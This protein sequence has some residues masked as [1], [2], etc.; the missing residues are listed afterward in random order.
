[1]NKILFFSFTFL[2]FTNFVFSQKAIIKGV[3]KDDEVGETLINATIMV[4]ELQGVGVVT[5]FDGNYNIELDE[6]EYTFVISYVGFQ[7]IEKKVN[8]KSNKITYLNASLKSIVINEVVVVADIAKTRETPVAFTNILPAKIEE[9]LAAQDMPMVL[10]STPGVYATQQGGGDG[11]ARITIRGFSQENIAV[12]LDGIPMNDM[13]SGRVY[14]SNWFG[15]D[16]VTRSMQVQRGLGSSKLAVPSVGGTVN[17]LTKGI[18]NK[19]GGSF[20]QDVGSFGYKRTTIGFNTGELKH[21][22]GLTFAASYKTKD[23]YIDNT[24]SEAL[25]YYFKIDKRFNLH[26]LSFSVMNAPQT[27]ASRPY[28][29]AISSYDHDYARELGIPL[30][31]VSNS[32]DTTEIK[33]R[34]RDY[35]DHWG[36]LERFDIDE[37]GDTIHA[38]KEIFREKENKYQ[39]PVFTLKDFWTLDDNLYLSTILYASVGTGGMTSKAASSKNGVTGS[40]SSNFGFDEDGQLDFQSVY[41]IN[42]FGTRQHNINLMPKEY[43]WASGVLAKDYNS[44]N[45]F[46]L[47]STLNYNYSDNL[48]FSG[49]VDLRTYEGMHYRQIEDLLG[50]D[51]FVDINDHTKEKP[52]VK[53]VGDKIGWN[54]DGL[55]RWGGLFF[56]SELKTEKFS[57]F[58]NM[59][60]ANTYY[61]KIDYFAR[62][63]IE[64]DG[65]MYRSILGYG[66][67]LYSDGTKFIDARSSEKRFYSDNGDTL[68]VIQNRGGK[69]T[70]FVVNPDEIYTMNSDGTRSAESDWKS[71]FGYT[72]KTGLNY[73]INE[74]SNVFING[75]Y[76]SKAQRFNQIYKRYSLEFIKN[77]KNEIVEAI[78]VGYNYHTPIFAYNLNFYYTQW[79]NK[80]VGTK[81]ITIEEETYTGN[82]N[83]LDV[84][85]KGIELDFIYKINDHF[86]LQSAFSLGDWTYTSEAEFNYGAAGASDTTVIFNPKGLHVSDAAQ[87]QAILSLRYEPLKGFYIKTKMTY[88]EDYY[89]DFDPSKLEP[90]GNPNSFD[91]YNN[92]LESWVLPSYYIFDLHFGYSFMVSKIKY[93]I[94]FNVMNVFDKVY[95]SD[96]RNNDSY[97]DF[98]YEDFD[99]KSASV[100]FGMP[101]RYSISLKV[102]F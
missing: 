81:T 27:H 79:R 84:L 102:T 94:K 92:P 52:T 12:M 80:P 15:L 40:T 49:G 66:D 95:I 37:N 61:N 33:E 21:E 90:E 43:H 88:F 63:D 34:G 24:P 45:W 54:Y 87:R 55:V 7:T 69:D 65:E 99:A 74:E 50:A 17:I 83:G 100:F 72:F 75:G 4:K 23:G 28:K 85:H 3:I 56:Q 36:Y 53:K 11:D 64:I 98:T 71:F 8:A 91:V 14:W 67:T 38:K 31:Y 82:I 13:E 59:T 19:M 26:T 42:K 6:G 78:E 73:N 77:I 41:N 29:K 68:F 35:N 9:E 93:G 22:I 96:A 10:N 62:K 101:R 58:L 48:S 39:K 47:L 57:A 1:M 51:Y 76:L 46:G 20:K 44:H 60:V 86:E 16:A 30:Y 32:G 25:F 70:L 5:D 2:F 18:D 97:N 89:A